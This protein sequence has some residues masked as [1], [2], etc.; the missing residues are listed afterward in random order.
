MSEIV[1]SYIVPVHPH[2]L[3]VSTNEGWTKLRL[4][5][6][7]LGIEL[8]LQRQIYSSFIQPLG[9][10]LSVIKFADPNPVWNLV[11]HDFHDLGTMEYDFKIDRNLQQYGMNAIKKEDCNLVP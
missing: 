4:P 10:V 1:G 11:D 2:P 6:I 8:L 5:L 9:R 7:L 3:L